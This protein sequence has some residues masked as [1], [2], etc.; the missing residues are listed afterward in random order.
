MS[1]Q[2]TLISIAKETHEELLLKGEHGFLS[3]DNTNLKTFLLGFFKG[4][5]YAANENL[6]ELEK[7]QKILE[8]AKSPAVMENVCLSRYEEIH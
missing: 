2:N 8:K 5:E 4:A 7:M 6:H 3:L 1:E